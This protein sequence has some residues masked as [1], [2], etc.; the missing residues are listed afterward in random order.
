MSSVHTRVGMN[1]NVCVFVHACSAMELDSDLLLL[2]M[3]LVFSLLIGGELGPA[4]Q[5]RSNILSKMEQRWQL[6]SSPQSVRPLAARG[7]AAR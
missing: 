3:D 2:L 6:I 4:Q 7:V 5:L 1:N